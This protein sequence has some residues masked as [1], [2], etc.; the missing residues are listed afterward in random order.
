MKGYFFLFLTISLILAGCSS[1]VKKEIAKKHEEYLSS[2]GWHVES[3]TSDEIKTI[4]YY[5][6]S[7]ESL[8]IAG[9]DLEPYQGKEVKIITY[10][11]K[12]GQ[13]NGDKMSASI[14]EM[15]NEIIGGHGILE[16]WSPGLFSLE[17]R[18]RLIEEGITQ[19]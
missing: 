9:L 1:D 15:D 17:D 10:L 11:L 18:K 8:K 13:T 14:Y 16:N 4:N 19:P 12:E 5:P 2:S 3:K 6:E 7:L